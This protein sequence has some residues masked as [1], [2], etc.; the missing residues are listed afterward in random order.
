[1]DTAAILEEL[2]TMLENSGVAI[3]RT[4]LGGDGGGLCKVKG[5]NVFFLDTESQAADTAALCAVALAKLADIDKIYIKPEIR[6]FIEKY[7][8]ETGP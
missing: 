3:R 4:P 7:S 6:E 8:R 1:M 2:L 5:Q